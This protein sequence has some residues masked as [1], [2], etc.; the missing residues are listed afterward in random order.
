M[1]P[2]GVFSLSPDLTQRVIGQMDSSTSVHPTQT[3]NHMFK[4][5][6]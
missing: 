1:R 6:N 5:A 3:L 2:E 4:I